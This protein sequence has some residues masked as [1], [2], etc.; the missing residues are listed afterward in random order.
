MGR[1]KDCRL[2]DS[3]YVE[4]HSMGSTVHV[5]LYSVSQPIP[6]STVHVCIYSISQPILDIRE[7]VSV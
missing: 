4:C 7:R 5:C 1:G 3:V 2:V 6:E